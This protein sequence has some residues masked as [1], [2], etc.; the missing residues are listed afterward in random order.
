MT[1]KLFDFLKDKIVNKKIVLFGE[2]HGTKETPLL[3]SE[4][5]SNY[6]LIKD[7]D[8]CLEIPSNEQEN[9]SKFLITGD[10]SLINLNSMDS[11]DGRNSLEMKQLIKNIFKLKK[12]IYCIDLD[13][14]LQL[15]RINERDKIMAENIKEHIKGRQI[16]AFLG[17]IHAAKKEIIM[18]KTKIETTGSILKKDFKTM[19]AT[20]N[21][22]PEKGQFFNNELKTIQGNNNVESFYDYTFN[23]EKVTPCNF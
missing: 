4:F 15:D 2:I 6:A 10:S 14:N 3:F 22:Q 16:I 18:A 17:N 23:I 11:K 1:E 7:F 9:I 12:R 5:L 19:F 8:V 13:Y 21:L 20:V